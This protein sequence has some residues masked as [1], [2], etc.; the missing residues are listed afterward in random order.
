MGV[1]MGGKRKKVTLW[2]AMVCGN[3]ENLGFDGLNSFGG[4]V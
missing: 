1:E 2:S 4:C 3:V